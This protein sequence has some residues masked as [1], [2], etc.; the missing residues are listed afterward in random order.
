M[1]TPDLR[2]SGPRH[3]YTA[4]VKFVVEGEDVAYSGY[5]RDIAFGG[6][7]VHSFNRPPAGTIVRLRF[8]VP[9]QEVPVDVRAEVVRSQESEAVARTEEMGF[10]VRFLVRDI[11]EPPPPPPEAEKRTSPRQA[12][13]AGLRFYVQEPHFFTGFAR[14]I[15]TGGIFVHTFS[16][17]EIGDEV[18]VRFV[19]PL[20]GVEHEA[21]AMVLWTRPEAPGRRFDDVGFGARFLSL[22]PE[23]LASVDRYVRTHEPEFY[24]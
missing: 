24:A 16:L 6:A 14:D 3:A 11:Y 4:P 9:F 18:S 17:P 13:S 2:R 15:S 8:P 20:L 22:P 21:R 12:Y 7:F 5:L 10:G 19:V 23:I 1:S